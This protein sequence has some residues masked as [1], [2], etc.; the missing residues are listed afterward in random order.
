[1]L[2]IYREDHIWGYYSDA[3]DAC[4]GEDDCTTCHELQAGSTRQG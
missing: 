1:M 2:H 3:M 4:H